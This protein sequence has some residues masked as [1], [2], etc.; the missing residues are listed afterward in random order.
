ME[1]LPENMNSMG[2]DRQMKILQM[3]QKLVCFILLK[4]RYSILAIFLVTL[5]AGVAIRYVSFKV[6][7]YKYE[8]TVTLFYTPRAS[9]EVKPLSI[10]QVLAI[11]SRQQVF[12][13]I[14]KDL[15]LS[16]KQ[17]SALQ[18]A[19][20][21]APIR[22]RYDM[23]TITAR[24][25]SD[26]YVKLLVNTYAAI[27]ESNYE[28]Y[29]LA[30]LRNYLSNRTNRLAELRAAQEKYIKNLQ[31]MFLS[32]EISHPREE[33]ETVKKVQTAL[34]A[35]VE[36]MKLKLSAAR[37]RFELAGKKLEAIPAVVIQHRIAL[38]DYDM[39]IIKR[40]REYEET[41]LKFSELNPRYT[42]SRDNYENIVTE[43]EAFK[44]QH[45]ITDFVPVMLVGLNDLINEYNAAEVD[46]N[47]LELSMKSLKAEEALV[48][49]K[50]KKLQEMMPEYDQIQVLLNTTQKETA[51]LLEELNRVRS[52]IDH[53][54][55]DITS[56]ERLLNTAKYPMFPKESVFLI[57]AGA[58]LL[59]GIYAVAIV[60]FQILYGKFSGIEEAYTLRDLIDTLGIF[61][62]MEL[63]LVA[64]ERNIIDHKTFYNFILHLK[65]IRVLFS[66]SLDGSF[67]SSVMFDE[68]CA[69]AKR[70]T[71]LVRLITE[72]EAERRCAG[73]EKIGDF[74]YS[75]NGR[76]GPNFIDSDVKNDIEYL[77]G[78]ASRT[79]SGYGYGYGYAFFPVRK[80]NVLEPDEISKLY[81]TINELKQYYQLIRIAREKPFSVAETMLRQLFDMSEGVLLYIGKDQTP[82]RLIRQV[83][84]LQDGNHP[85]YAIVTGEINIEKVISGD[86][87]Q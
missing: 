85:I 37:K 6:S 55:H 65:A 4:F 17:L 13:Q 53:V 73:M 74:Y 61:P 20:E 79:G 24:G 52:A 63:P 33:L 27:A 82:R 23:F 2:D 60:F 15:Q 56:N 35:S 83:I 34:L 47:L 50:E 14:A 46:L 5:I 29:R 16:D 78:F 64:E 36:E 11:C 54:P 25:D 41:R 71:I 59:C 87:N 19:I 10:N 72:S 43:F 66:C 1:Q 86:Y 48:Q 18:N 39:E 38:H 7:P 76:G 84:D 68:Q 44:Q 75:D 58:V 51:L 28:E 21:V 30:E 80:L 70:N 8:G 69:K 81:R 42:E 32:F 67:R 9:E 40:K 12:Q 49:S 45:G 31:S 57:L 26:E 77:A 62:A 22:D 3:Y